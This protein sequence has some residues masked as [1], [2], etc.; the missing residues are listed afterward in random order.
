MYSKKL[1]FLKS[2]I[3]LLFLSYP[4]LL[5]LNIPFPLFLSTFNTL[6]AIN[7]HGDPVSAITFG[8]VLR[9]KHYY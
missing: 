7:T 8:S 1:R 5:Y 6:F 9:Q 3:F 4:P 2:F